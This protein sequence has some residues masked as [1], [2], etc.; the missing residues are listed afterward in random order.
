M[1][2]PQA[3]A[4]GIKLLELLWLA[5]AKLGVFFRGERSHQVLDPGSVIEERVGHFDRIG[6]HQH[7]LVQ[8]LALGGEDGEMLLV[9]GFLAQGLEFAGKETRHDRTWEIL[10]TF[11]HLGQP[12]SPGRRAKELAFDHRNAFEEVEHG[13]RVQLAGLQGIDGWRRRF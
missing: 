3:E 5:K 8:R 6:V 10:E 7:P 4:R 13:G 9:V 2:L 11:L 1:N 12:A